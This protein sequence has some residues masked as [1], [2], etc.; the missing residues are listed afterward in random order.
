MAR[1]I[2]NSFWR[3]LPRASSM[4]ARLNDATSSTSP[5]M[6]NSIIASVPMPSSVCGLVLTDMRESGAIIRS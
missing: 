3:A 6:E 4:F 5:D 1:R 2:A